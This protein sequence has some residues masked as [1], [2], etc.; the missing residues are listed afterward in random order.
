M[1]LNGRRI[2]ATKGIDEGEANVSP[3]LIRS[4]NLA[5]LENQGLICR[6]RLSVVSWAA[7]VNQRCCSGCGNVSETRSTTQR[8]CAGT[9]SAHLILVE[10]A[11]NF[12]KLLFAH[13]T[14]CFIGIC[15]FDSTT[16]I[17]CSLY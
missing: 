5:I 14:K 2:G 1:I 11:F 15:N 7:Y 10:L 6:T 4:E 16:S 8:P 3:D 13:L 12:A 9:S 17:H